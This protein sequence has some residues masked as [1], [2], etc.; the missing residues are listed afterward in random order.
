METIKMK[1]KTFIIKSLGHT[2]VC[3]IDEY[4]N[5]YL[6]TSDTGDSFYVDR[7]TFDNEYLDT[8]SA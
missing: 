7:E 8:K 3:E 1:D 5:R 6:V 4:H 2:Y